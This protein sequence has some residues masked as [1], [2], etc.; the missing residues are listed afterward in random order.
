MVYS[1]EQK[2]HILFFTV[3]FVQL[4]LVFALIMLTCFQIQELIE[5][6]GT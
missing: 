5:I 4:M 2:F 3:T 6:L 1:P